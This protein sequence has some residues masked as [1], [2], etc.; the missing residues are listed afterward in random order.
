MK[1]QM[2]DAIMLIIVTVIGFM[3]LT[4][5]PQVLRAAELKLNKTP[6]P[7]IE[8]VHTYDNNLQIT[9]VYDGI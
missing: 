1:K 4:H 5:M 9:M 8:V 2:V 3:F 7:T 6:T